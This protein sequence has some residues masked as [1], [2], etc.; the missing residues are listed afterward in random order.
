[1]ERRHMM[2]KMM[3]MMMMTSEPSELSLIVTV[4]KNVYHYS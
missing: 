4:V 1:M 3:T 2:T